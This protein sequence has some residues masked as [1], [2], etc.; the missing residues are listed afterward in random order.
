VNDSCLWGVSDRVIYDWCGEQI[1]R[2]VREC[3]SD[4]PYTQAMTEAFDF[5]RWE[6]ESVYNP[7]E[8]P[9]WVGLVWHG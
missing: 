3:D 2:L 8:L 4:D 5:L 6:I 1:R 9:S 7:A